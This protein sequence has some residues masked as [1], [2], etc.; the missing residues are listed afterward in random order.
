MVAQLD[1]GPKD[2]IFTKPKE[3]IYN[4]KSMFM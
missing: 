2:V 4:L 1:F 3:S